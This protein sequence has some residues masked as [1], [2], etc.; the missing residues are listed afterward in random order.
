MT[1]LTAYLRR[2]VLQLWGSDRPL[3][4]VGLLMCGVLVATGIGLMVDPRTIGG[5][6]AW[7]KPAKFAAS[8]A[9][10]SLTLAWL[11]SFLPDWPRTQR[12]VSRVTATVFVLEVAIIV[13][14]AS[15]GVASHFNVGTPLDAVL[16][17]IMGA[18]IGVQTVVS[19]LVAVALWR[20]PIADRAMG[21]ALRAG[22]VLTLLGA[23]SA[24]LMTMPSSAQLES[25]A[26]THQMPRAGGHTVGAPDGGAGLPGTGW[27]REHGDLRT[28]HFFGLHAL[29][30]LPLIALVARRRRNQAEAVRL[31]RVGA[32]SYAA[33]FVILLVQAL[34][35]EALIAPGGFTVT[36]ALLWAVS[37]ALA[38]IAVR[39][40]ATR[41]VV[42]AAASRPNW[43]ISASH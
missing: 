20:Q 33:L 21:T 15:R 6:P 35:G 2:T 7:L 17:A 39:V 14:Q 30:C 28:P 23:A 5:D 31:V 41:E 34:R 40:R 26:T 42:A 13:I 25:A 12:L 10:Y 43:H 1:R 22:M 36:L 3:T 32:I 16:F 24:G 29:Q 8:T 4:A 27:S 9:V 19:A 37:T 18:A 38:V 11:L